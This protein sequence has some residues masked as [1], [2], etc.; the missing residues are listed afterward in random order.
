MFFYHLTINYDKTKEY[1]YSCNMVYLKGKE[2][3]FKRSSIE[4]KKEENRKIIDQENETVKS[5]LLNN[6]YDN[7]PETTDLGTYSSITRISNNDN[8]NFSSDNFV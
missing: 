8:Y 7:Q 4:Q 3:I 1:P 2:D 6:I 5:Q